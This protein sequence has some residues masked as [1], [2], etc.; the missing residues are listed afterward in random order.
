MRWVSATTLSA[1]TPAGIRPPNLECA[2][3]IGRSNVAFIGPARNALRSA[4]L[5]KSKFDGFS[6]RPSSAR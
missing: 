4:S 1:S 2:A 6:D 3:E 5:S